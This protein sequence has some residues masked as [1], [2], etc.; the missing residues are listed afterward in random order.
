MVFDGE[1]REAAARIEPVGRHDRAGRT[2]REA[3]RAAAAVIGGRRIGRERQVREEFAQH[4]QRARAGIDQVG[5]LA[6][7]AE[8]GIAR[9][10]FLQ[11][12]GR[13]DEGA[14]AEAADRFLDAVR[15]LLQPAA[16]DVVI[17][18][19]EGVARDVGAFAVGEDLLRRGAVGS[20]AVHAHRQ[21]AQRAR[22]Q[23]GRVRALAAVALHVVHVAVH[24]GI[25]PGLQVHGIG[26]ESGLRDADLLETQLG[27]ESGD[28]RLERGECG[29]RKRG[30]IHGTAV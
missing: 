4:E 15:E 7:P 19:A 17:V 6:D 18:A 10:R 24:A 2:G 20:Q 16:H 12:R 8:P 25:E 11:Y 30:S 13:I 9:E 1:V 22:H 3:G 29:R 28:A 23:F 26:I 21:H 5:V 14:I 27:G